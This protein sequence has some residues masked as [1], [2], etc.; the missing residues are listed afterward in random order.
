MQTGSLLWQSQGGQSH[1]PRKERHV[2]H[3]KLEMYSRAMGHG[4]EAGNQVRQ[5]LPGTRTLVPE[6]RKAH[7][8]LQLPALQVASN[9]EHHLGKE[10]LLAK[11]TADG[12]RTN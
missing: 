5:N 8:M 6:S 7:S 12:G 4:S 3:Q 9:V 2:A 11:Y 1:G 10:Q